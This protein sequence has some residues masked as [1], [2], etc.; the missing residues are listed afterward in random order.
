[1]III[2]HILFIHVTYSVSPIL[3][4]YIIPVRET[5]RGNQEWTFQGQSQHWAQDKERG[6]T[7]SNVL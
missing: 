7:K 3:I 5:R 1:M 2:L 6:Q 4:F